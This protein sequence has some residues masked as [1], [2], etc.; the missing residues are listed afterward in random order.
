MTRARR[1][2]SAVSLQE[3]AKQLHEPLRHIDEPP[4]AGRKTVAGVE[5]PAK[6]GICRG[7]PTRKPGRHG[8]R[9]P[10][11][12][13]FRGN[14]ECLYGRSVEGVGATKHNNPL[15]ILRHSRESGNLP[16]AFP[17]GKTG[18][19]GGPPPPDSRFRGN[20]ECLYGRSAERVGA[21]K[22]NNS[23]IILRHSRESGRPPPDSRFRGNDE[24][25][26]GRSAERVGAAKHNN[27]LLPFVIP[28]K[29]EICLR[30]SHKKNRADM[31]DHRLR[32]PAFAGMTSVCIVGA[33]KGPARQNTITR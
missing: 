33:P 5:F 20:D 11:D 21:A 22:R 25:L 15:I 14:D 26:Y 30:R 8:G 27:S 13:R 18:R 19:Y 28:A 17:Q 10:P 31:A 6:A 32:I 24:C 7:V 9:P 2:A 12:S 3:A 29:T 4:H 16:A 1:Q 23:L